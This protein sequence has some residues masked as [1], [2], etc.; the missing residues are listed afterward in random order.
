[1]I[2]SYLDFCEELKKSGFSMAGA[3]NKGIYSIIPFDW[4]EAPPEGCV[5][6]WHSE[7]PDVDPWM[8]RMRVLEERND[9]AYA[10]LFF[11]LGGYITKEWYPYF[12]RL[13]RKGVGFSDYFDSGKASMLEKKI[14]EIIE[15]KGRIP[16]HE[17]KSE[18]GINKEETS[19]FERAINSLQ[20]KMFITVCGRAHKLNKRGEPYGWEVSVFCTAED[21]WG[22]DITAESEPEEAYNKIKNQVM[23]LN[24]N[25][26]EKTIK[27][28][29]FG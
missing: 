1:M 8:W 2:N 22:G 21:F 27:K 12:L 6:E 17:I 24:P 20:M 9:I 13:R 14:Y 16:V 29:I 11:G 5:L 26:E 3:N 25:A 18:C 23:A 4:N 19:K 10:K 7:K 28:F 15:A